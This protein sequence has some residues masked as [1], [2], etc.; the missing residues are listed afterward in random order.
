LGD[1][2]LSYSHEKKRRGSP[3]INALADRSHTFE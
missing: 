1:F 3:Y 2:L